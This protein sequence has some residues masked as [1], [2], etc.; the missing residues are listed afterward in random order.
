M[1]AEGRKRLRPDTQ[2]PTGCQVTDFTSKV[3]TFRL[4]GFKGLRVEVWFRV[5]VGIGFGLVRRVG[6]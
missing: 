3:G 4:V 5:G 2:A 6:I 1:I